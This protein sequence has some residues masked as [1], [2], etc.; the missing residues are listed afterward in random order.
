MKDRRLEIK[1]ALEDMIHK[2]RHREFQWLAVQIAKAKWP[3]LEATQEQDDGGEDATS[4]FT[5]SDGVRRRLACS[6]TG[7]LQ[8]I[9]SD[10]QRLRERDVKVDVLVF[11]TAAPVTNLE[12]SKWCQAVKDECGYEVHIVAQAELITVLENPGN[13]WLCRERL[14]VLILRMILGFWS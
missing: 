5:G 7:K 9:K 3:E 6:L 10:A 2:Q 1:E 12:I 8:K 11:I 4:F 13:A 14:E